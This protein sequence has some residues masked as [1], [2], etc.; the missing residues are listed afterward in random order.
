MQPVRA[1]QLLYIVLFAA[2]P[3][4]VQ[5]RDEVAHVTERMH[6]AC[7]R[8]DDRTEGNLIQFASRGGKADEACLFI[9]ALRAAHGA[10]L[11]CIVDVEHGTVRFAYEAQIAPLLRLLFCRRGQVVLHIPT[12]EKIL[13]ERA[14]NCVEQTLHTI[15]RMRLV[16]CIDARTTVRNKHKVPS[17]SGVC[18]IIH[19]DDEIFHRRAVVDALRLCFRSFLFRSALLRLF[20]L[21]FCPRVHLEKGAAEHP[22]NAKPHENRERTKNL[23][24]H[25]APALSAAQSSAANIYKQTKPQS[26]VV[27]R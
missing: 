2:K 11:M 15:A 18:I 6:V 22:C 3:R 24:H 21:A 23:F 10:V 7:I 9:L 17:G 27:I 16:R 14:V 25:S 26:S 1:A 8:I 4:R 20:H 5:Q 19:F 13:D 12:V